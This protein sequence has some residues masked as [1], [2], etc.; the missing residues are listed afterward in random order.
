MTI[1]RIFTTKFWGGS[2]KVLLAAAV[3]LVIVPF[4]HAGEPRDFNGDGKSDIT[5]TN[6]VTGEKLIWLMNGGAIVGGGIIHT[7]PNWSIAHY[8]DFD[9]NGKTDLIWRNNST[10]ETAMWLMDGASYVDSATLMYDPHWSV[11]Q[12]GKFDSDNKADLWWRKD[13]DGDVA[14]WTMNGTSIIAGGTVY[15]VRQAFTVNFVADLDGDGLDDLIAT[16]GIS[17]TA[18]FQNLGQRNFF[19]QYASIW[20]N[21]LVATNVGDFNGDGRADVVW[22]RN[23]DGITLISLALGP[24]SFGLGPMI[25]VMNDSSWV[26]AGVDDFNGDGKADLLWRNTATGE[27]AIW[28]MDGTTR[29]S[30]AG[31][32]GP[33]WQI[34]R[35]GDFNGDGKADILFTNTVTHEKVMWLMDG[36]WPTAGY[37]LSND[38]AWT[39]LP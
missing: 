17:N 34:V 18:I 6:S 27:T 19:G 14:L 10:G 9:G 25:T 20:Y 37:L 31:L 35:T 23:T 2:A 22:R 12:I 39:I 29:I 36:L 32:L 13:T 21:Q 8:G 7:D 16:D 38:P 5:W 28:L 33:N 1:I 15:P 11:T 30:G 3:G 24:P 26:V 4:A